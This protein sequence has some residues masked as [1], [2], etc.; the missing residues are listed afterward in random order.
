MVAHRQAWCWERIQNFFI[1]IS[2]QQENKALGL[3]WTSETSKPA[4]SDTFP[5]TRPDIL[6]MPC[7][8]GLWDPFSFKPPQI[9]KKKKQK[10]NR[11][12]SNCHSCRWVIGQDKWREAPVEPVVLPTSLTPV[13]SYAAQS[14]CYYLSGE[15]LGPRDWRFMYHLLHCFLG[16]SFF[17][18]STVL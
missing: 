5:P 7:P 4:P 16:Y 10:T 3:A 1:W 8:M 12:W 11:A 9:W 2:S 13:P 18:E 17:G 14:S 6:I 15:M